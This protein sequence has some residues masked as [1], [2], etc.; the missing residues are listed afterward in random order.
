MSALSISDRTKLAKLLGMLSSDH[1]GERAAAALAASRFVQ[2][3]NLTWSDVVKPPPSE[4]RQPESGTWRQ[5]VDRCLQR[6]GSLR[7]WELEFLCSLPSFPRLSA[8]QKAVLRD[9]AERVLGGG[10]A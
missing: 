5:T 3:R 8:K 6:K 7:V 1:V 10:V 2:S 9:I 4:T